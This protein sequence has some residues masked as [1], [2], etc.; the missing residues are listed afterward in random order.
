MRSPKAIEYHFKYLKK[1]DRRQRARFYKCQLLSRAGV[2]QLKELFISSSHACNADCVHCYEK[3]THKK[4]GHSLSTEQ[5]KSAVK[6][7]SELGGYQV[8][9]CSGEFLLRKDAIEQIRYA[10]SRDLAV[11]MTSNGILLDEDKVATLD[12]AG[13]TKLIVSVDSAIPSRHNKL[14]GVEGCFENATTGIR[15]AVRRG[16]LTEIWT[17]VSRSNPDEL[18]GIADLGRELGVNAVFVF[19]PLLSG[20]FYDKPEE[21]LTL[22]ERERFRKEYNNSTNVM[23]EFPDEGDH[24]R[25]GGAYHINVMPSGDVTYCPAVPYSYGNIDSRSLKD[26]LVDI[27]NDRERL[28]HCCLGQCPV[29]FQEYRQKCAAKF[30]YPEDAQ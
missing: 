2:F 15:H 7:L 11:S 1:L 27:K 23:L 10:R 22:E 5:V 18:R 4:L 14:R 16:I 19:F 30:M 6:Q 24:C 17:Y 21:N 8:F 26:C 12:D 28:A 29:N 13:L 20:H 25:G 3:F 9:F